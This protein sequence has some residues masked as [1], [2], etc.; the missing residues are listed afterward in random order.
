M[1]EIHGSIEDKKN[2]NYYCDICDVILISKLYMEKHKEGK[3]HNNI[4]KS[5]DILNDIQEKIKL[6]N[7]IKNN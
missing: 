5:I 2:Y 1:S 7:T 3:K 4:I 6:I